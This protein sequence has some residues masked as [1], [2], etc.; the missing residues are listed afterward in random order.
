MRE[1]HLDG[2]LVRAEPR[3]L[4]DVVGRNR[5]PLAAHEPAHPEHE[6]RVVGLEMRA[7]P[8]DRLDLDSRLLAELTLEPFDRLLAL[9]EKPAGD[10][11]VPSSRLDPAPREEHR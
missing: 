3:E 5:L 10:V 7:E 2:Q 8:F 6:V 4:L 9:L 11:P 1:G